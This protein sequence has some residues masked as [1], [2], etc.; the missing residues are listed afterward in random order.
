MVSEAE[1][2]VEMQ[3]KYRDT[4]AQATLLAA[5]EQSSRQTDGGAEAAHEAHSLGQ[6]A[7]T[8]DMVSPQRSA[9]AEDFQESLWKAAQTERRQPVFK[10]SGSGISWKCAVINA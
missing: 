9:P 6:C 4:V 5:A 3:E 10:L 1:L 2:I 7:P 8:D